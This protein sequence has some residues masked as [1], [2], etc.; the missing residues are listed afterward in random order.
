MINFQFKLVFIMYKAI[1]I[2]NSIKTLLRR[3]IWCQMLFCLLHRTFFVN[4]KFRKFC[5]IT[6]IKGTTSVITKI[7]GT[8][9][10]EEHGIILNNISETDL[11][12][13]YF[14]KIVIKSEGET[15]FYFR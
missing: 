11:V 4:F 9:Y 3:H 8:I 1:Q 14:E 2:A 5:V 15:V 6:K 7:K 10:Q 12:I 13:F